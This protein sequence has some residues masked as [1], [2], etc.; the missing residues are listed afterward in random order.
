M[1]SVTL[2]GKS[3]AKEGLEFTFGGCLSKCKDCGLKNSCCGLKKNK[4]YRIT[5]V[6][7]KSHD[8]EV[9]HEEVKVVEVEEVPIKTAASGRSVIEGSVITLEEKDCDEVGCENYQ[10][11]HPKGI[12]SDKKYNIE[13]VG[14]E[15]ECPKGKD[16][17]TVEL[18]EK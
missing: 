7:S 17:K 11:C 2:I 18:T 1:G 6:R 14:E 12:E 13:S 10:L 5:D 4:W 15:I 9:H 16:L 3:L 8:C